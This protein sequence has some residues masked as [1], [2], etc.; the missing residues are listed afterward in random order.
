LILERCII[1]EVGDRRGNP[2]DISETLDRSEEPASSERG[3]ARPRLFLLLEYDRPSASSER[4]PLA[5][6]DEVVIGRSHRRAAT[7]AERSLAIGVP[8]PRMSRS[9]ARLVTELGRWIVED[10]GSRN[11]VLVNGSRCDR[12]LLSDGDL[13]ELGNTLFLY[14]DTPD[15][16]DPGEPQ[17][18]LATYMP[19][20]NRAFAELTRVA[21]QTGLSVLVL[22]ETGTGKEL[23]A[24]A[25]HAISGR[26]GAFVA[27]NCA[28]LPETLVESELF[29]Y[30]KGAFSGAVDDRI[31]FVRSAHGG[32]LF[33]DEIGDLSAPSQAVLL[34]VLQEREVTPLGTAAPVSV[35]IQVV[36]AT[37]GDLDA[38]VSRGQFRRDLLARLAGYVVRLPPLRE[39]RE[40]MG[41]LIAALISRAVPGGADRIR[42]QVEA[43]RALLRYGWPNNVR[44][45]EA[46]LVLATTLAGDGQI[47]LEHL[48]EQVLAGPRGEAPPEPAPVLS[49]D[50]AR[51]RAE[52]VAL[53]EEHGGNLSAVARATGKAR[54][55]IQRWVRRFRLDPA[56][57]RR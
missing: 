38:L 55:Q 16:A 6:L 50:D 45:L 43:A 1:D 18:G 10:A 27:V 44:E 40:D 31:G 11:R 34:R 37:H 8:D 46:A 22:G 51:R 19:S 47:R 41:L 5:G 32:T 28:A 23:V 13:V 53:L 24:R 12:A 29:G 15:S 42:F 33:L 17:L 36:A 7:V 14:R 52:L 9:H 57:F 2:P 39:R 35:D 56:A 30:R 54:F 49:P 48:P 26:S 20:L 4:Y 3:G 25:T 21:R